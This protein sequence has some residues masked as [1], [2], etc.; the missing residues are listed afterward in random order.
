MKISAD[1]ITL[2]EEDMEE[3]TNRYSK[4][5]VLAMALD[6]SFECFGKFYEAGDY[7]IISRGVRL[8]CTKK[9]FANDYERRQNDH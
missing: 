6:F 8:G 9:N 2:I 4:R 3:Y 7:I 5:D 1:K